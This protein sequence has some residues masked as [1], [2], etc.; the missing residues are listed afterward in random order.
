MSKVV[1][2]H[3]KDARAIVITYGQIAEYL[4]N[5]E[6]LQQTGQVGH[7]QSSDRPTKKRRRPSTPPDDPSS[8]RERICFAKWRKRLKG[9]QLTRMKIS[10]ARQARALTYPRGEGAKRLSRYLIYVETLKVVELEF[11]YRT[12]R[13]LSPLRQWAFTN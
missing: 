5:A 1:D 4:N 13:F 7:G 10:P 2:F 9:T 8:D 6:R 12:I 3:D 11:L